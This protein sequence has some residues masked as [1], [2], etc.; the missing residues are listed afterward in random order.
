[1]YNWYC[2]HN[3]RRGY[4]VWLIDSNTP[5]THTTPHRKKRDERTHITATTK[6]SNL[7]KQNETISKNNKRI[8]K[9]NVKQISRDLNFK[10]VSH[11]HFDIHVNVFKNI[12]L[13]LKVCVASRSFCPCKTARK[14]TATF[15]SLFCPNQ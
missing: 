15:L 12:Q 1:M 9:R 7:P 14:S 6:C 3:K 5:R 11:Y 8:K 2:T 4:A 13:Q 10:M